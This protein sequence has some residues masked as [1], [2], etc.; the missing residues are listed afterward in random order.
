M[1]AE[2]ERWR[3]HTYSYSNAEIELKLEITICERFA[4][5]CMRM[6]ETHTHVEGN[7]L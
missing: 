4:Y 3:I 1:I 7:V 6:W 5:L 2:R